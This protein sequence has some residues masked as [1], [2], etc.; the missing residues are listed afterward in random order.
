MDF[1]IVYPETRQDEVEETYFGTE[2]SDPY[3]WLEDD[4]SQETADWVKK[5]N[6]LTFK[7]LENIPY[8]K[9]IKDR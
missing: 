1:D 9:N 2:V 5:Q 3:R 4:N 7:Y 8:R 6:E